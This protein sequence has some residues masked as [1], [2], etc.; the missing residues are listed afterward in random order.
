M[1]PDMYAV[2][3]KYIDNDLKYW[4]GDER[5]IIIVVPKFRR[6]YFPTP[7]DAEQAI[8]MCQATIGK[9]RIEYYEVVCIQ[10][11]ENELVC[12]KIKNN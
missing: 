9:G 5:H 12:K 11:I 6:K 2:R 4:L 8:Q 1:M 10:F 7:E 3:V